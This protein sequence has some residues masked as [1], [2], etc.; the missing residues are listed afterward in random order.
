MT[1]TKKEFRD[2]EKLRIEEAITKLK[3]YVNRGGH[4]MPMTRREFLAS[5]VLKMSATIAIPSLAMQI[6]NATKANAAAVCPAAATEILPAYVGL[7]LAGGASLASNV[8]PKAQDKSSLLTS[9]KEIGAGRAPATV[10]SY[11]VTWSA[12]SNFLAGFNATLTNTAKTKISI[13]NACVMSFDDSAENE[14]DISGMITSAGLVGRAL[15]NLGRRS[16]WPSGN[17]N[18]S[19][20][21]TPPNPLVLGN[22][23]QAGIVLPQSFLPSLNEEQKRALLRT[24]ANIN[25]VQRAKFETMSGGK[26]MA[27]LLECAGIKNQEVL[28]AISPND[29]NPRLNPTINNIWQLN[30][31]D[32]ASDDAVSATL[33]YNAINGI[34]GAANLDLGEYDGHASL[35]RSF[36][37]GK[38]NEAGIMAAKII[39]TAEV[40][41]RKLFLY[42]TT[43]GSMGGGNDAGDA[44]YAGDRGTQGMLLMVLFDPAGRPQ[45]RMNQI[46]W[47]SSASQE[48]DTA[49]KYARSVSSIS[50][51]IFLNYLA[52]AGKMNNWDSIF[53][54]QAPFG[55]DQFPEFLCVG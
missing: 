40:L 29:I 3:T 23:N 31:K 49:F 24:I 27:D 18:R 39:N 41:N 30:G 6:L 1:K 45:M 50:A 44:M 15:P 43:D 10:N 21:I 5:G 2:Q 51:G 53:N 25:S 16:R 34:A 12:N 17:S 32:D 46:G 19:S 33:A 35:D 36:M 9:Y 54:T 55:K 47:F 52:F 4:R 13:A 37:N 42:I 48:V 20:T 28:K 7:N 38:D 26:A 22:L 8:L 11:G 14:L